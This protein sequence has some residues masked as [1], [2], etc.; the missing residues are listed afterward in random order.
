MMTAV[1]FER[2]TFDGSMFG[3]RPCIRGLR[4][5]VSVVL[6]HLADGATTDE[7]LREYPDLV[8]EDVL[9]ALAFAA[10]LASNRWLASDQ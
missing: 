2:I 8:R 9:Q 10:W 7:I 3:G 5:P 4:V 1:S 6:A